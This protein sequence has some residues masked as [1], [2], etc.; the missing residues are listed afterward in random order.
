MRGASQGLCLA[1]AWA[2][3]SRTWLK[4]ASH[5]QLQ[6]SGGDMKRQC[7]GLS[8][9]H[10][11]SHFDVE[12][13]NISGI[14]GRLSSEQPASNPPCSHPSSLWDISLLEI[15]FELKS[16]VVKYISGEDFMILFFWPCL[17]IK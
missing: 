17:V 2:W 10:S 11:T 15:A 13:K 6:I 7:F 1:A 16:P 9:S 14:S 12:H 3:V 5:S 4:A 8:A